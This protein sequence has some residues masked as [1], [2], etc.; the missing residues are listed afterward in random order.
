MPVICQLLQCCG[1][2][3][4]ATVQQRSGMES[5]K[6][7]VNNGWKNSS[8][9]WVTVNVTGNSN[10]FIN[11]CYGLGAT[12][13]L[14]SSNCVIWYILCLLERWWPTST[15]PFRNIRDLRNSPN[16]LVPGN[17]KIKYIHIC[18][19]FNFHRW[20][21]QV[22]TRDVWS[23]LPQ[24]LATATSVYGSI[25]KIDST[26]KICKKL[27]GA[28]A[29]T[30]TWVTNVGNEQGEVLMSVVT[31]AEGLL[32][33]KNMADGLMKRFVYSM[34]LKSMCSTVYLNI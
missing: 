14:M 34:L 16:S 28:A 17:E 8:A 9:T 3:L 30:A 11:A 7:T 19:H 15:N 29:G 27:Q 13:I 20:L 12:P 24:L 31:E 21:L 4:L 26:K 22:Y 25:L 6:S 18:I 1:E 33:L 2:G 5:W 10:V 23:R 32:S